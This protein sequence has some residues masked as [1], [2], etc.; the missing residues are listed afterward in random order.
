MADEIYLKFLIDDSG[1]DKTSV[2]ISDITNLL[3]EQEKAI[4][5]TYSGRQLDEA[6]K[7][8]AEH[9]RIMQANL[10]KYNDAG[11]ALKAMQDELATMA[12]I[13]NTNTKAY[14]N[15][16]RAVVLLSNRMEESRALIKS[17]SADAKLLDTLTSGMKGVNA[18][19]EV[20]AGLIAATGSESKRFAEISAQVKGA[21]SAATSL[22]EGYNA[23]TQEGGIVTK[24][25]SVAQ[26]AYTLV[27]G[28]S[29]G[30]MKV[31]KLALAGTGIGLAVIAIGELVAHWDE[32]TQAVG[33]SNKNLVDFEE[34]RKQA[35]D[36]AV[37]EAGKV[38]LLIEKY[39]NVT[40]TQQE[41]KKIIAE[42]KEQSPAYFGTLDNEKTSL[43]DLQ[44]AYAKY[45]QALV[46][47]AQA[48]ILARDIAQTHI[49]INEENNKSIDETLN[50]WDQAKLGIISLAGGMFGYK[51]NTTASTIAAEKHKEATSE[52]QKKN[53]LL[54]KSLNDTIKAMNELGG[55]PAQKATKGI[56]KV[57]AAIKRDKEEPVEPIKEKTLTSIKGI[58]EEIQKEIDI[59]KLPVIKIEVETPMEKIKG[60]LN[61]YANEMQNAVANISKVTNQLF[62]QQTQALDAELQTKLSGIDEVTAKQLEAAGSN[63]EMRQAIEERSAKKKADLEKRAAV[64]KAKIERKQAIANKVF[65]IFDIGI[66]MAQAIMRAYSDTGPIAGNV[67]AAITAAVGAAELAA[68]A[69]APLPEIPKFEKGGPVALSGGR[70]AD[71]HLYGRSHRQG[72]MLIN[73]QGGEYIWD[74]PTVKKH[75]DLIRAAHENRLEDLIMH[76]YIVPAMQR[77]SQ[78]VAQQNSYDDFMLRST[79]KQGHEKERR[80]AEYIVK[81]ITNGL[82]EANYFTKRFNS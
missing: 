65:A 76:K 64:E 9:T 71:G 78:P 16:A 39:K 67:F 80:N 55:D 60:F 61:E 34:I 38:E 62:G 52:L 51:S 33:L 28:E 42:L 50:L 75:G 11:K 77:S 70:I 41:R 44:V 58:N 48:E 46:L 73:A 25:A 7:K 40:T 69:A 32:F 5:S 14:E 81:G 74:I 47:K 10:L 21:L 22:Q 3:N 24:A 43:E 66:K 27:V 31:F 79:I 17:L 53:E 54:V 36:S 29:T 12:A 57:S 59:Q 18:A 26:A 19:F 6:N 2:K 68:V 82:T 8:L 49:A 56:N 35:G 45:S 37:N 1:F 23:L 72:G 4:K 20:G 63:A 13:G 30:A 15:T